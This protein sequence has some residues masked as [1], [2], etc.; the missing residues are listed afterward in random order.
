MSLPHISPAEAKALIDQGAIL[1]DIRDMDEHAS[2]RIPQ[3]HNRP[4]SEL[5]EN[6][7]G[8]DQKAIVFHC[9]SGNRTRMNASVLAQAAEVDAFILDGGIEAWKKAGL[10]VTQDRK[11]PI[12]IMRQVQIAAGG[13]ALLGTLLGLLVSP[14][15]YALSGAVGAGLMFSGITGSCAMAGILKTMPWNRAAA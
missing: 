2:E 13:L 3:A 12:E 4:L 7:V 8:K 15:F 14:A 11:Q 1:V 6:S 5:C 10:P 9:K